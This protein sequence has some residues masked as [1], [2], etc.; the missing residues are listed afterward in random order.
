[1]LYVY[2]I[3]MDFLFLPF[4]QFFFFPSAHKSPEFQ[5]EEEQKVEE[6]KP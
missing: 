1:M 6:M 5:M 2:I 3:Q 4:S